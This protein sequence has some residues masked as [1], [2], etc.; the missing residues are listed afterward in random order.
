[1]KITNTKTILVAIVCFAVMACIVVAS[2]SH[3][4]STSVFTS[5]P[6]IPVSSAQVPDG[7]YSHEVGGFDGMNIVLTK[8]K[9]LP[10]VN[11]TNY[12]YE[13]N[14]EVS[15]RD[16]GITPE[17]YVAQTKNVDESAVQF[18]TWS[19]SFGR[20]VFSLGYTLADGKQQR[21]YLFGGNHVVMITL[22]PDKQ[23]NRA[24]FQQV[25]NYYAQS[26]PV[27]SRAETLNNCKTVIFTPG[28]ERD[29][30]GDPETGYV[31]V[32]YTKNGVQTH[33]YFNYNDDL[34]QCTPSVH[35]LLSGMKID[36][37]KRNADQCIEM[38]AILS[39]KESFPSTTDEQHRQAYLSLAKEFVK[40]NCPGI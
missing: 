4:Y 31:T 39:G 29:T 11:P 10:A 24:A 7:W 33:A 20:K 21:T 1:M 27:I 37:D 17:S 23:E 22:Y 36:V 16:I 6:S 12:S 2:W 25:V 9:D 38:K 19:T 34:S 15:I 26:L 3:F 35:D 5:T 18:A 40:N 13:E 30:L 8:I 28:E 14:I 32:G